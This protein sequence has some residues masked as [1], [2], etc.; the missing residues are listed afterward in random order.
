MQQDPGT[1]DKPSEEGLE[2]CC[3]VRTVDGSIRS[4]GYVTIL[5]DQ[6]TGQCGNGMVLAMWRGQGL[7]GEYLLPVLQHVL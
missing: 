2:C 5:G 4:L 3:T 1:M 6:A 7:I